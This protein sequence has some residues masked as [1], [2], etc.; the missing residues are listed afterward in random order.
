MDFPFCPLR[1]AAPSHSAHPALARSGRGSSK[2]SKLALAALGVCSLTAFPANAGGSNTDYVVDSI[3]VNQGFSNGSTPLT[4]GRAT[5][6]RAVIKVTGPK[7]PVDGILRVYVGGNELAGSPFFS[8]NGPVQ[9][10]NSPNL[11]NEDHSLNFIVLPPFSNQ[12]EFVVEINPPGP[13]AAPE[14]NSSNN[15]LSSGI[16]NFPRLSKPE[17]AYVPIDYRPS[18]GGP[19]LPDANLIEPGVGDGFIHGIYPVHDWDYHRSDAP[20]KLWTSSLS[21]TGSSLLNS[22][23][24]DLQQ[25]SPKPDFIYGWVPGGLNYNG[26]ANLG[27]DAGMGNT[28]TFRFQRTFAH[29]LGH[30]FGLGHSGNSI[31]QIGID[32]ER[33]LLVTEN[34]GRIK[35]P[36][37]FDIMVAG[38]L[39]PSAWV[40]NASYSFFYNHPVFDQ[41]FNPTPP[42]GSAPDTADHSTEELEQPVLFLAGLWNHKS[43]ELEATHSYHLPSGRASEAGTGSEGDLLLRAFGSDGLLRELPF[44]AR[45]SSDCGTGAAE[46][47]T[48]SNQATQSVSGFSVALAT[49]DWG[50]R[51]NRV[52]LT[53]PMRPDASQLEWVR[54]AHAPEV[55][56]QLASAGASSP[57][58]LRASWEL[59]DADGDALQVYLR[60]SPDGVRFIPLSLAPEA[61]SVDLDL[62]AY[63]AGKLGSAFLE[64]ISSDGL[65]TTVQRSSAIAT[66]FLGGGNAPWAYI[67]TPDDTLRYELGA[68]VIL[69]CAAWDL[70]D[71]G[72]NGNS[73]EWSS[74]ID[75][76]IGTGRLTTVNNLS[77]GTHVISLTATDSDD[78]VSV[79]SVVISI[80]A[81][82]L[83]ATTPVICQTDLGFGGPGAS[84]LTICGGDLST[85]SSFDVELSGALPS[86]LAWILGGTAN[87]PTPLIGGTVVPV[88][89]PVIISVMTNAGGGFQFSGIEGGGGPVSFYFQVLYVDSNEV[90]GFG[91]SN[92]VRADFLP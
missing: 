54:S 28:Q 15:S 69:H 9:A 37:L 40:S 84:E 92:C 86:T 79:D 82:D 8:D 26:Q 23:N 74:N 63:P 60:Y 70:E 56:L 81:R 11:E 38:Q 76:I 18:G 19:N 89:T 20:S 66:Q 31:N 24:S 71:N 83:P 67:M 32:V 14:S 59:S 27:G 6:I 36:G 77:A 7:Q 12:V 51:V 21:G 87:N 53:D 16:L 57:N 50:R 22:L 64:L 68:N 13:N 25:M 45:N 1:P 5:F 75:G 41:G 48:D 46:L 85:G 10:K 42:P 2:L 72:L 58:I 55:S 33:H 17:L 65:N 90:D 3:E 49:K 73:L 88:P 47:N 62:S 44:A 52:T 30:N 35:D 78:M 4:A 34:L 39:T 29:E 80:Q 91:L 43:G 61:T